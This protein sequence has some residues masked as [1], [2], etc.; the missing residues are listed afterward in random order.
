MRPCAFT[1]HPLGE[2]L[3]ETAA[4]AQCLV[5]GGYALTVVR[6]LRSLGLGAEPEQVVELAVL[7]S[8]FHDTGKAAEHYQRQFEGDCTC[9]QGRDP[10]FKYHELISAVHLRRY[11]DLTRA[12]DDG[13]ALLAE[14]AVLNH[15]HALRDYSAFKEVLDPQRWLPYDL[16]SI[17]EG[18]SVREEDVEALVSEVRGFDALDV[19]AFRRALPE[20]V[21]LNEEVRP[22]LNRISEAESRR[23]FTKLY[24]ALLLPVVVGDNLDARKKR[25][26][27]S[28]HKGRKLF[29][30]ELERLLEVTC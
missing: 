7:A 25:R 10:S 2:H 8:I 21:R 22:L 9:A 24:V 11:F 18:S 12:Y 3:R 14:M 27:D 23:P 26:D 15:M 19:E 4:L 5:R 17:L 6:R 1:G 28:D 20:K 30:E 29:A 16:R 13:L